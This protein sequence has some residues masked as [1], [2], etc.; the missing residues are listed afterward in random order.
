ML[1]FIALYFPFYFI[2]STYCSTSLV[3]FLCLIAKKSHL[4]AAILNYYYYSHIPCQVLL[5]RGSDVCTIFFIHEQYADAACL[6]VCVRWRGLV[7]CSGYAVMT[8]TSSTLHT[9]P[10]ATPHKPTATN[11]YSTCNHTV[12][13]LGHSIKTRYVLPGWNLLE[14]FIISNTR[15]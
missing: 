7:Y 13:N 3:E 4:P 6:S 1:Y 5:C 10:R 2:I 8:C 12:Y 11:A 9:H 15:V 14:Q